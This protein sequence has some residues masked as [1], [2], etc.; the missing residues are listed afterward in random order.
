MDETTIAWFRSPR[1]LFQLQTQGLLPE[2][3]A[4]IVSQLN[5]VM[6][7]SV[8]L[9]L[10]LALY[11]RSFRVPA[12]VLGTG[13]LLTW[14]LTWAHEVR[15]GRRE[16]MMLCK[17]GRRAAAAAAA[18]SSSCVAPSLDNPFMNALP[19]DASDRPSACDITDD[20]V[21]RQ[22][23]HLFSHNLYRDSDDIYGRRAGSLRQYYTMPNT[24]T[25]N[26]QTEF[27]T[28][29]YGRRKVCRAGDLDVCASLLFHPTQPSNI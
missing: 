2:P 16:A 10:L 12:V 22:A 23:E 27:A 15:G 7:F 24:E 13:A 9:A 14:A 11:Q 3:G 4:G 1:Q 26:M 8:F 28:W 29:L 17:G 19:T 20:D 6:R 25:P 21:S 5:A 18:A